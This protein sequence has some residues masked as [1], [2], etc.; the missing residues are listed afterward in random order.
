M[1]AS[2]IIPTKN[3]EANLKILLEQIQRQTYKD[4]EVV[5]ADAHSTDRT[6][7]IA[8]SFGAV[9]VVGGMPGAGRNLGA[10]ASHGDVL[11]FL[12]ADARLQ[13]PRLLEDLLT[14]MRRRRLDVCGVDINPENGRLIERVSYALYNRYARIMGGALPHAVGTFMLAKRFIHEAI[15]GF[16][17]TVTLAE[18]MHYARQAAQVGEFGILRSHAVET[19]M[20][21]WKKEGTLRL[22]AK[23]LYTELHMLVKG[24]IRGHVDYDFDYTDTS[25]DA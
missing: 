20:R 12:D 4:V 5:V 25:T 3:E 17:E 13:P 19:P 9:V 2:L 22:L 6:R 10:A 14:E 7:E 16:D 21:R 15:G 11:I 23:Y 8:R 1:L 24:P 18:D